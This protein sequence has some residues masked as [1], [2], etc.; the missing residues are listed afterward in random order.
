MPYHETGDLP[1]TAHP[2]LNP[3]TN[4][5]HYFG[6]RVDKAPF[7]KYGQLDANGNRTKWFDIPTAQGTF[8]HDFAATEKYAI[9]FDLSLVFD[10]K[11][12]VKE[13]KIPFAFDEKKAA[14]FGLLP[15]T[16]E[17]ASEIMWFDL[18]PH[19]LIHT[20]NAWDD[21]DLVHMYGCFYEKL[22][23]DL[24]GGRVLVFLLI[25]KALLFL[26]IDSIVS[27]F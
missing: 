6:Y 25:V 17:D 12:M 19:V 21:G 7:M 8:N 9:L 1:F 24:E 23:L 10:G 2:K 15:V 18:P 14:R 20:A 11:R 16:A 13:G 22:E 5:L 26:A 3:D 27:V 4:V